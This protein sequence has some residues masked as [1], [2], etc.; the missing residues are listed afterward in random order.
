MP[1]KHL[2]AQHA[3]LIHSDEALARRYWNMF[4]GRGQSAYSDCRWE[5]AQ[6]YLSA[7]IDVAVVRLSSHKGESFDFSHVLEPLSLLLALYI[8]D[9]EHDLAREK[10]DY[11]KQILSTVADSVHIETLLEGCVKQVGLKD[12]AARSN[13]FE[14]RQAAHSYN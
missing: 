13:S 14:S 3:K 8:A 9:Q 11:V 12:A 4:M 6:I 7:A 5:G 2:C 1:Y 10:L